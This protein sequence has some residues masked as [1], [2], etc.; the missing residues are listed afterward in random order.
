GPRG[1]PG[2]SAA[3]AADNRDM[4]GPAAIPDPAPIRA[5]LEERHVNLARDIAAWAPRLL[6]RHVPSDDAGCRIEARAM[7]ETL[8]KDRWLEPIKKEDWRACCLVREALAAISPLAD[9]VFALQALGALPI[10][11]NG[12][13]KQR[14]LCALPAISGRSM[15]A[16]AMTER[17]AGSHLSAIA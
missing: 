10:L 5:F 8:G 7:L 17:P 12:T 9:A 11:R 6:K 15:A 2:Q 16:F 13:P 14:E 3:R 1:R 4:S